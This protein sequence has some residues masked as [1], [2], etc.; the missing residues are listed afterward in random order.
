[1]VTVNREGFTALS[2]SEDAA[3]QRFLLKHDRVHPPQL[4]SF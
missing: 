3:S 4:L 1:M 2:G